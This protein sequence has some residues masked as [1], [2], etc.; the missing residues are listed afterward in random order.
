MMQLLWKRASHISDK[1]IYQFL[2]D[3]DR[4]AKLLSMD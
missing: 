4:N 3:G 1:L 2:E